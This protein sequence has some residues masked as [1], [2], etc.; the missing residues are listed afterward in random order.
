M[1]KKL[2]FSFYTK[3]TGVTYNNRQQNIALLEK[4]KKLEVVREVNNEYDKNAIELFDGNNSIGYI[5]SETVR[6]LSLKYDV[7]SEIEVF[8]EKITGGNGNFYGVNVRI[9]VYN[10]TYNQCLPRYLFNTRIYISSIDISEI[11]IGEHLKYS[12]NNNKLELI[13]N[14]NVL[15]TLESNIA[16]KI[17][18][19]LKKDADVN[20]IVTSRN[21]HELVVEVSVY[22][23]VNF[24]KEYKNEHYEEEYDL[25]EGYEYLKGCFDSE[26]EFE[27]YMDNFDD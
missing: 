13:Y 10:K 4:G 19:E 14:N 16:N 23:K 7:G 12:F 22:D 9:D 1:S 2:G 27:E 20:I 26:E 3:L 5:P 8:V 25:V 15:G 6:K 11:C 24:R 18:P 21:N 17:I